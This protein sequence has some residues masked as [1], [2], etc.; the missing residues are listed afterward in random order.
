MCMNIGVMI[1]ASAAGIGILSAAAACIY[2]A[3]YEKGI[4][5]RFA[6]GCT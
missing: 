3:G 1:A 2:R 6:A 4:S 5:A